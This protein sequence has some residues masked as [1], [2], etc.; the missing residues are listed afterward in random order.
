MDEM[1][2]ADE[3]CASVELEQGRI[4]SVEFK[5]QLPPGANHRQRVGPQ[6][7]RG[8]IQH[9][10]ASGCGRVEEIQFDLLHAIRGRAIDRR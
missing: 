8:R 2:E 6:L 5:R 4:T 7:A 10:H 9:D 3:G 1:L